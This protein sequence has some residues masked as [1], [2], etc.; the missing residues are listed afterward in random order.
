MGARPNN[1]HR[2]SASLSTLPLP[3]THTHTHLPRTFLT[4]RACSDNVEWV[5]TEVAQSGVS[6]YLLDQRGFLD[7]EFGEPC[8]GHPSAAIDQGMAESGAAFIKETLGW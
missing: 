1:H 2:A 3:P 5:I 7:G 6:A 8:C 4:N